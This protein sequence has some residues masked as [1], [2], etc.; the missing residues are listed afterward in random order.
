MIKLINIED[1]DVGRMIEYI[2]A[3]GY[4]VVVEKGNE[5]FTYDVAILTRGEE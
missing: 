1:S 4:K 3:S 5:A 2:V